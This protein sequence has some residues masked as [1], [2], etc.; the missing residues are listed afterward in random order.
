VQD[1]KQPAVLLCK[2]GHPLYSFTPDILHSQSEASIR[3]RSICNWQGKLDDSQKVHSK[4]ELLRQSGVALVP[5]I[6]TGATAGA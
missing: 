3:R 1:G 5:G 6:L 4:K 2:N